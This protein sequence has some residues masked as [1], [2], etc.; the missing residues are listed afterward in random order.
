MRVGQRVQCIDPGKHKIIKLNEIYT[1]TKLTN[2]VTGMTVMDS[3]GEEYGGFFPRR[4]AS[5]L[6]NNKTKVL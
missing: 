4:F 1:I 6:L 3:K 5:M 2:S